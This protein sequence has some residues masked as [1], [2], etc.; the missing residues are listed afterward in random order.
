MV[1]ITYIHTYKHIFSQQNQHNLSMSM[2]IKTKICLLLIDVTAYVN[3]LMLYLISKYISTKHCTE[4]NLDNGFILLAG[5]DWRAAGGVA[6][7]LLWLVPKIL[8]IMCVH[9]ML[10]YYHCDLFP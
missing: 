3:R 10:H 6:D 4:V 2:N 5:G 9:S 7:I 8:S 1:K